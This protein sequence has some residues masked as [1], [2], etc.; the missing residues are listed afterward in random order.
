MLS[1]VIF[2][3]YHQK[4]LQMLLTGI[5]KRAF[6]SY[7]D[8]DLS[9]YKY[10]SSI[11]WSAGY[12]CRKCG[13]VEYMKGKRP[14]SRRCKSCKYDESVTSHT[15]FH[16]LKFS[17]QTAFELIF[18]LSS[19]KKGQSSLSLS[20]ELGISYECCLNFRRKVQQAMQAK[21]EPLLRTRVEVDEFVVGGYNPDSQGRAKGTKKLVAV[22]LELTDKGQFLRGYAMQINDYSSQELRKIFDKHIDKKAFVRTDKWT[23]YLPIQQVYSKLKQEYSQKG[24]NFKQL[25]LHIMNI[26]NWI[27]GIHHHV[28]EKYIQRYLD[29]FHFRFNRRNFR[30]K[31]FHSLIKRMM[32]IPCI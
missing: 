15:L 24:R 7:F 1:Q 26:K 22:A 12:H 29:E 25:H 30:D 10:L 11:K 14:Y 9:C 27:R 21:E 2:I 4:R 6:Y 17:I 5:N 31:L 3:W 8:D 18:L 13:C 19:E 16:K 23:G 28:S 32:I 20:E